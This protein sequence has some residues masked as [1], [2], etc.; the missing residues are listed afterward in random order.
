MFIK[1]ATESDLKYITSLAKIESNLFWKSIGFLPLRKL[2]GG[3][4]R[5]RII[6]EYGIVKG[7]FNKEVYHVEMG[8]HGQTGT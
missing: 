8:R 3:K 4:Q 2:Q 5:G 1:P 6:Q 7:L